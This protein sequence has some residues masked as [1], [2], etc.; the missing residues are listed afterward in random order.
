MGMG[1]GASTLWGAGG[2]GQ[3]VK[4]AGVRKAGVSG[5]LQGGGVQKLWDA[6][7][8]EARRGTGAGDQGTGVWAKLPATAFPATGQRGELKI[9]NYLQL[10]R[11][12]SLKMKTNL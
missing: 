7:N 12:L 9:T 1:R 4:G 2:E 8:G 5:R 10:I 3:T 11:L 6:A